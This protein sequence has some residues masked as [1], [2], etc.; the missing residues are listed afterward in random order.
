MTNL[1]SEINLTERFKSAVNT[2]GTIVVFMFA[3]ALLHWVISY[4]YY[5]FC[6]G[7]TLTDA[8]MS[9]FN[10]GGFGCQIL[11]RGM[12]ITHYEYMKHIMSLFS[13]I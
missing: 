9:V 13:I 11:F 10:T 2:G 12:R 4:S 7:H 3:S 5:Q 8:L 1:H 6:I